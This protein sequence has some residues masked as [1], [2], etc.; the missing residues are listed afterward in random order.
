MR[1]ATSLFDRKGQSA[2]GRH[3]LRL[4]VYEI[5]GNPVIFVR[6]RMQ[7]IQRVDREYTQAEKAGADLAHSC[8]RS[9]LFWGST[10]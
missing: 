7:D 10:G 3:W 4:L 2:R 1:L 9:G 6:N 5:A 8:S